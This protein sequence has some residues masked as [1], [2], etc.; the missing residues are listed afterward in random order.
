MFNVVGVLFS[1]SSKNAKEEIDIKL[2]Q[3]GAGLII[4]RECPLREAHPSHPF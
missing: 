2:W 1:T 4:L 3:Q